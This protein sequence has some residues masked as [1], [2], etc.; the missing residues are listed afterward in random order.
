MT[1]ESIVFKDDENWYVLPNILKVTKSVYPRQFDTQITISVPLTPPPKPRTFSCWPC[2]HTDHNTFIAAFVRV[3]APVRSPSADTKI[4]TMI[5][6]VYFKI[7]LDVNGLGQFLWSDIFQIGRGDFTGSFEPTHF[8][9]MLLQG[10][11]KFTQ[12]TQW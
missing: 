4:N 7:S 5:R 1:T 9:L 6:R 12:K 10:Y 8:V 2:A 3:L 11:A